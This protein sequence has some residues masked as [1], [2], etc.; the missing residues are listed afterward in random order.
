MTGWWDN[1]S[2]SGRMYYDLSNIS[3]K[4]NGT[5]STSN[6]TS[7]D[8]KRFYLG[9]DHKFDET[10]SANLTTDF[11]YASLATDEYDPNLP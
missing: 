8:I 7:F 10:Y 6:G 3:N 2:I 5:A 11:T 9:V 1:T 4:N